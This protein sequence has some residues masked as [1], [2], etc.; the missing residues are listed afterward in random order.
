[1]SLQFLKDNNG[2]DTGVFIPIQDWKKLKK[3]Y[4]GLDEIETNQAIED[5][6][7]S[8]LELKLIE[9]GKKKS[10]PAREFMNELLTNTK[11]K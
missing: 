4:R 6:K 5:L 3:K 8:L 7:E 11:H 1:M 2:K 9:Q 10:R